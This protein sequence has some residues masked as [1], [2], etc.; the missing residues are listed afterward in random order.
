MLLRA[1]PG[2][3]DAP[4]APD[5]VVAITQPAH[6]WVA[7]Q[8][9]RAWAW[10]DPEGGPRGAPIPPPE[11]VCL[12]TEQHDA[13]W[14]AWEGAPTLDPRTGRPHTFLTLPL[15]ERLDIWAG[16]AARCVL[17]QSRYAAVLVSLHATRLHAGADVS[18]EPPE[19]AQRFR[20]FLAAEQRF[21]DGLLAGLR[22]GPSEGAAGAAAPEAVERAYALLS[23]CDRLSLVLCGG[24]RAP[25]E[26]AG[27]PL[28]GGPVTLTL[29]P[30]GGDPARVRVDPWP[31][32]GRAV[33]L[34]WEGRRLRGT[35][36]AAGAMR[37]ALAAAP[38]AT[39]RVELV[40]SGPRPAAA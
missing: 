37:A 12:A 20:D 13:G 34:E 23:T 9:A 3:P 7:G 36:R 27:A 4:D 6:G 16:A 35:F 18:G 29:A 28:A 5:A 14:A 26:V 40:P 10:G 32:R 8:L 21:R 15:R 19:V 17:P 22:A 1:E 25:R 38:W 2:G 39:F 33:A 11:A 31:F 30:E 24:L